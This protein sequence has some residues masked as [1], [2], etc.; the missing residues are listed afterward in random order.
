MKKKKGDVETKEAEV[1]IIK[2]QKSTKV[3]S[4]YVEPILA[5]DAP[6][7]VVEETGVK[8]IVETKIIITKPELDHSVP[9]PETIEEE[10]TPIPLPR[11][12]LPPIITKP[13]LE[14]P[15]EPKSE[16]LPPLVPVPSPKL[17]P[18]EPLPLSK[19]EPLPQALKENK[20]APTPE[21]EPEKEASTAA[22]LWIST[23]P[24][25]LQLKGVG[26]T[27]IIGKVTSEKAIPKAILPKYSA[28]SE[29]VPA[30]T[31]R[32]KQARKNV[33]ITRKS[34]SVRTV[35]AE[36]YSRQMPTGNGKRTVIN[37]GTII[38]NKKGSSSSS[39]SSWSS[40]SG[41]SSSSSGSQSGWSSSSGAAASGSGSGSGSGFGSS[42]AT[43]RGKRV[44]W[45]D[46]VVSPIVSQPK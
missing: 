41:S 14:R 28:I 1:T 42:S 12:P 36:D 39:S 25:V 23:K 24:A 19:P 22:A 46:E 45:V 31:A 5:P 17:V 13:V 3:R 43:T 44:R 2:T 32:A 34:T 37:N 16:P 33:V 40:G 11:T 6:K 38:I 10:Q 8:P 30:I 9:T 27:E 29:T 15:A 4:V 18:V 20:P 21:V 7:R 26:G 35:E